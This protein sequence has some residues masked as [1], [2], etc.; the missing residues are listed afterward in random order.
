MLGLSWMV[1]G[2]GQQA[3]RQF[4]AARLRMRFSLSIS[5]FLPALPYR[6]IS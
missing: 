6:P 5:P 2:E 3:C 1:L 4:D